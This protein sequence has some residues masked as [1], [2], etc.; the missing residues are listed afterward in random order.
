MLVANE[1]EAEGLVGAGPPAEMIARLSC[2]FPNAE[3]VLTLGAAG[4][5]YAAD[6]QQ[7]HVPA[8]EVQAVDTTAAGDTFLGYFLAERLRGTDNRIC[9]ETACRAAALAISRPGAMDS[10]PYRRELVEEAN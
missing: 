1:S 2:K 8:V 10:I 7:L 3:L 4:V 5:L 9:L 6:G